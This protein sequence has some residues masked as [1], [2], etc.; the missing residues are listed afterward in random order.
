[1]PLGP[2]HQLPRVGAV[3]AFCSTEGI[4]GVLDVPDLVLDPGG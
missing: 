1:M 4:L 2:L 3:A